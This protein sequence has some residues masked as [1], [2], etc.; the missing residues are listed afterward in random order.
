V[1]FLDGRS[2]ELSAWVSVLE[3]ASAAQDAKQVRRLCLVG[4]LAGWLVQLVLAFA[5]ARV[6]PDQA[7]SWGTDV[8]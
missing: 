6:N 1:G 7:F 3:A 8:Y 5:A 2:K 4:W